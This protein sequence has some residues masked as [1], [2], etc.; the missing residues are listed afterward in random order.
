MMGQRAGN[1]ALWVPTTRQ[2]CTGTYAHNQPDRGAGSHPPILH[3]G[4][5]SSENIHEA[6]EREGFL[7][8]PNTS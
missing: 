1:Y 6:G 3:L 4:K 2:E 8:V 5:L 7:L